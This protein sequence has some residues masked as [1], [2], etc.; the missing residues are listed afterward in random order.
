MSHM[1]IDTTVRA[2]KD[3]GFT[4][5]L[6]DDACVANSL[7]FKNELISVHIVH[8]TFMAALNGIFADVVTAD[9]YLS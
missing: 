9:E 4:C 6:I 3:L 1:G 7:K 2:A 8:A 5:T